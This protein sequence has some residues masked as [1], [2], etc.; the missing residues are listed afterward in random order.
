MSQIWGPLRGDS[1]IVG[2][3]PDAFGEGQENGQPTVLLLRLPHGP[4]WISLALCFVASPGLLFILWLKYP[5]GMSVGVGFSSL[6]IG[7][8]VWSSL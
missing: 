1:N 7:N 3:V 6:K 2:K 4:P 5:A 8:L